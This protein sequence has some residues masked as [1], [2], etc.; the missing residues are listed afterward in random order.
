MIRR[1]KPVCCMRTASRMCPAMRQGWERTL[2]TLRFITC[3]M[4]AFLRPAG[5]RSSFFTYGQWMMKNTC[6]V[7]CRKAST[8]LS[9]INRMWPA[10]LWITA[11][12]YGPAVEKLWLIAVGNQQPQRL[13]DGKIVSVSVEE[14]GN[15]SLPGIVAFSLLA[16]HAMVHKA[17]RAGLGIH[18][19]ILRHP[20]V[21]P[22]QIGNGL[23]IIWLGRADITDLVVEPDIHMHKPHTF[24]EDR[25]PD[26][27]GVVTSLAFP[28]F[29]PQT[30]QAGAAAQLPIIHSF[31]VQPVA[32]QL[33]VYLKASGNPSGAGEGNHP[34]QKCFRSVD[35]A[36][37]RLTE[38]QIIATFGCFFRHPFH[39]IRAVQRNVKIRI[40]QHGF[41]LPDECFV[42][43][44]AGIGAS[45]R[46][47]RQQEAAQETIAAPAVQDTDG[48]CKLPH[49][50]HKET[51]IILVPEGRTGAGKIIQLPAPIA[52]FPLICGNI[53]G[54]RKRLEPHQFIHGYAEYPGQ[55]WQQG[56]IRKGDAGFPF[57]DG[58]WRHAQKRGQ[59][60][61]AEAVL[62][63]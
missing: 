36:E 38:N 11:D 37:H 8:R 12:F 28:F 4:K 26:S 62:F 6:A 1:P 3:S 19:H 60:L 59:L 42:K 40:A 54:I 52:F 61:L 33:S 7:W 25:K 15:F 53:G 39:K 31:N 56:N 24:H 46:K 44:H 55:L 50:F 9:Q 51:D 22:D 57:A 23:F 63:S 14:G 45:L 10:E 27:Y 21:G 58:L 20:V 47:Q 35:M 34:F 48:L 17:L 43:V 30:A 5:K 18:G 13:E 16:A 49:L 41:S 32:F 2:C 29:F